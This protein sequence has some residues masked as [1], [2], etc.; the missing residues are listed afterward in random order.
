MIVRECKHFTTSSIARNDR[1]EHF[2]L[3]IL[4]RIAH[5]KCQK[6]AEEQYR[7]IMECR[8]SGLTDHQWC[9]LNFEFGLQHHSHFSIGG[10]LLLSYTLL[11]TPF[12]SA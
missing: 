11:L 9:I 4:R 8:N 10:F 6:P 5:E 3:I 7:L 2:T 12:S 1:C